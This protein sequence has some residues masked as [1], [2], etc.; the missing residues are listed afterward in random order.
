MKPEHVAPYLEECEQAIPQ[1]KTSKA[2]AVARRATA[3]AS[4]L[5]MGTISKSK[6]K[7]VSQSREPSRERANIESEMAIQKAELMAMKQQLARY[8]QRDE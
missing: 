3:S 2:L 8:Q 4:V 5:L 6:K 7:D 1:S